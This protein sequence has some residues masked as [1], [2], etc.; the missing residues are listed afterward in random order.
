MATLVQWPQTVAA[1]RRR[2]V[3]PTAFF[4]VAAVA[5]LGGSATFMATD[6]WLDWPGRDLWQHTAALKS[7]I[8]DPHHP[9]NPFVNTLEPSRHFH[10]YW[11]IMALLARLF[12]WSAMQTINVAGFLVAVTIGWGF[13]LFGRA[14]FRSEWGPLA[15][16]LCCTLGWMLPV[17]HTGYLNIATLVEGIAYPAPR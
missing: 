6:R 9:L 17:S 8:A 4:L 10:P 7:L 5:I 14:Y 13:Y 16:L 12:G 15:A 3:S 2:A 11:A 1:H